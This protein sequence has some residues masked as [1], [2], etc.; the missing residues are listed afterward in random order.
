[1]VAGDG[2]LHAPKSGNNGEFFR[3]SRIGIW[4]LE[5]NITESRSCVSQGLIANGSDHI[6][7]S[8]TTYLVR[9]RIVRDGQTRDPISFIVES[10]NHNALQELQSSVNP[11][12]GH[13]GDGDYVIS[14]TTGE[15]ELWFGLEDGTWPRTANAGI[16]RYDSS[17]LEY[18]GFHVHPSLKY[19]A[20]LAFDPVQQRAYGSTW[21]GVKE[22]AVFD[23]A[24]MRWSNSTLPI[25]NLPVVSNT[26]V[27][28]HGM[29][30]THGINFIQGADV[31]DGLL[32]LM[33]DDFK[34]S[35]FV[36][37]LKK[38]EATVV[39]VLFFGL[40]NE[41]EG[42]TLFDSHLLSLGN[43]WR[44]W[45]NH[46][47][48]EILCLP[49]FLTHNHDHSV[50]PLLTVDDQ[51]MMLLIGIAF[52]SLFAISCKWICKKN[53]CT[54]LIQIYKCSEKTE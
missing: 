19:L 50:T 35:L 53:W 21:E 20:W 40:G 18:K 1:M 24:N 25:G 34:S 23:S 43:R 10:S 4:P 49:L 29:N 6:W 3:P 16:V 38:D 41:R 28:G 33:T 37:D 9:G 15:H 14:P 7:I 45:E 46:S 5:W 12:Y 2:P 51:I 42:I 36:F 48:A 27:T 32:Y 30:F 52:G 13:I 22:L 11:N 44:T 54:V 8:C 47:F 26:N 39:D 31:Q 17:T